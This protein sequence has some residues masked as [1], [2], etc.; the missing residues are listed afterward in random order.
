MAL[1]LPYLGIKP[2]ID[3]SAYIAPDAS[4]IGRV[5]IGKDTSIWHHVAIRGDVETI[6]IGERTNIQDGTVIH[7]SRFNGPTHIGDDITV[8]HQALLHACILEDA[9]FIGMGAIVMDYAVVE[10]GG[11]VAAGALITPKK[12]VKKGEIWAGNPGKFFRMMTEQESAYI[13]E[14]AKNYTELANE[15]LYPPAR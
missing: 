2:T 6:T 11:M 1:I 12:R 4:I 9:C 7:V 14:S 3:P 5:T 8:G 15:Y 13:M 10:T